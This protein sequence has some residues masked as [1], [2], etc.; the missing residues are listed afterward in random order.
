[1]L[2]RIFEPKGDKV[3]RK[4]GKLHNEFKTRRKNCDESTKKIPEEKDQL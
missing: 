1:V 3:T 4:W 2:R